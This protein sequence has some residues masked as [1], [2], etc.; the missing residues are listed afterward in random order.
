[1]KEFSLADMHPGPL[2]A[3]AIADIL[4]IQQKIYLYGWAIDARDF[5]ALDQVFAPDSIIHYDVPGGVKKPWHEMKDWLP[6]GLQLFRVTQHNMANPI[7]RVH[8]DRASSRT[9]GQ[10]V[11]VQHHKDGESTT[12]V[13]HAVYSDE[14]ERS[15]TGWISRERVLS[16]LYMNGAIY[17]PDRVELYPTPK[18][19]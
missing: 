10:L 11:H 4:E 14:W 3:D 6:L 1:M 12:M 2:A 19:Y 8:G 5:A 15:A 9:N 18:P 7:V 13:Q 16:N 17:G